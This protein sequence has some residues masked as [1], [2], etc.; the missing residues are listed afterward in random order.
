MTDRISAVAVS[1]TNMMKRGIS[2]SSSDRLP[3]TALPDPNRD[4]NRPAAAFIIK[5]IPLAPGNDVNFQ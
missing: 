4:L 2:H 3:V 1:A 5:I